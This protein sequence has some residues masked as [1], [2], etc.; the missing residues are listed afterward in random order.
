MVLVWNPGLGLFLAPPLGEEGISLFLLA[1]LPWV[2]TWALGLT[3][4]ETLP[5]APERG[6]RSPGDRAALP[7]LLPRL[8]SFLGASI[9]WWSLEAD[10]H[11]GVSAPCV[12]RSQDPVFSRWPSLSLQ[13]VTEVFGWIFLTCIGGTSISSSRIWHR[14]ASAH[15]PA[16]LEGIVFLW[17]SY[18]LVPLKPQLS[19]EFKIWFR[20]RSGFFVVVDGMGV[21][22]KNKEDLVGIKEMVRSE[23]FSNLSHGWDALPSLVNIPSAVAGGR[24]SLLVIFCFPLAVMLSTTGLGLGRWQ[25]WL[26]LGFVLVTRSVYY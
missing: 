7:G 17:I 15:V 16:L 2:F 18:C 8:R 4:V 5:P 12:C 25:R 22:F 24:S 11:V 14:R 20:S 26:F 10:P 23:Y 6:A 13:R 9:W 1:Q 21:T 3:G 19:G